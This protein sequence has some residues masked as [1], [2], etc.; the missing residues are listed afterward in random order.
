MGGH[1]NDVTINSNKTV[2]MHINLGA[3]DAFPPLVV[4][5]LDPHALQVVKVSKLLG[6]F[7]NNFTWTSHITSIIGTASYRL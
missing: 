4:T 2:L 7:I 3:W 1:K 5:K 6:A